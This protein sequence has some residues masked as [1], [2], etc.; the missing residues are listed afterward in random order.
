MVEAKL[1]KGR[2]PVATILVRTRHAQGRRHLRR[3]RRER[4]GPRADR[5]QGQAGQGSR[6]VDAGRG[7]RSVGR[8]AVPAIRCRW[9]R[10]RRAPARSPPIAPSVIQKKRTTTAPASLETMFSALREKQAQRVSGGGQGRHARVGRGDRRLAQQD[11]DRRYPGAHPALGRRR[12]H[13]ERRDAGGRLAARR[14]SASTSAPT[15]RRARSPTRD[16]V[17]LKYY[18]VIYDLLDEIRAAMAGQLGSGSDRDMSSA[19]P[20]SARSSRRA[21]MARRPVCSSPRASSARRC[22]RASRARTSSSTTA[23]SPRCVASR[24]MSPKSARAWS[25]A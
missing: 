17:A 3:R 16:Q 5:R 20:K 14:S 15:P 2:G 12:H 8:A 13:R 21:S 22:V 23:R 10:T 9:S 24:T 19:A 4:Q 6:P 1:D 11:L 25:A 7:A 18:D